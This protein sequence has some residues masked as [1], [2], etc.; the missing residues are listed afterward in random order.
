ML[1]DS[2]QS[3]GDS[4]GV[5]TEVFFLGSNR[6]TKDPVKIPI[7]TLKRHFAALGSSGSGKT[8]MCKIL[9]EEATRH[10]IPTIM[11]DPQGDIASLGLFGN[12]QELKEKGV[13]PALLEQYRS[14]ASVRIFTPASSKGIPISIQPLKFPDRDLPAEDTIRSLDFMAT[15]LS[16][17]LGYDDSSDQGKAAQSLL[18]HIFQNAFSQN[19]TITDFGELA[20][21][22]VAPPEEISDL[23][24]GIITP[25]ERNVLARRL[26]Y[27]TVGTNS[28]LFNYGVP[29]NIATFLERDPSGKTPVN[30]IYLNT[31]NDQED[32]LFFLAILARELYNWMLK[33]PSNKL[34]LFFYI[35]EIAP[36]LP[37]HPYTPPPKTMLKMIFK[38]ARKYGVG[39]VAATQNPT[40]LDYKAL[41]QVSTWALGRM[42]TKQDIDRVRHILR[43]ISPAHV[44]KIA[45]TLPKLKVGEFLFLCP[46][47]FKDVI[48]LK[49]RWLLSE[50]KT[51][52]VDLL[53]DAM[54][55]GIRE[56]L[57]EKADRKQTSLE[58]A[59]PKTSP[60][61]I[62]LN[63]LKETQTFDAEELADATGEDKTKVTDIL[64]D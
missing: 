21:T 34:Q 37:P 57:I 27:L 4:Q 49:T 13:D 47:V 46:D 26:R 56:F 31:L 60:R 2:F 3:S 19:I 39:L 16:R 33:H 1:N 58:T 48:P 11:V 6:K 28:L 51:L 41:A 53:N 17:F 9:M 54:P 59:A 42:M 52:D 25:R 20:E 50:H 63:Q 38:Q 7:G 10:D 14:R 61:A 30:I 22:V 15:T 44:D 64:T 35:D 5:E 40:D 32:K 24:D 18:F 8:V 62:I 55:E 36:Y 23:A 45:D 29:L 12:P 43:A